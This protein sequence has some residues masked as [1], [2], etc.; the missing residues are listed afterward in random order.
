M[1]PDC[2]PFAGTDVEL[3]L[4]C[5]LTP[6]RRRRPLRVVEATTDHQARVTRIPQHRDDF[7]A[8]KDKITY[9]VADDLPTVEPTTSSGAQ[10]P[11]TT[12]R[13]TTSQLNGHHGSCSLN[14]DTRCKSAT[15]ACA[16][17]K[18]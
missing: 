16:A 11:S 15:C 5:R 2:F 17:G 6:L 7:A 10:P 13:L 14:T 4:E 9:V 3:L 8:F 1:K 12:H 18:E